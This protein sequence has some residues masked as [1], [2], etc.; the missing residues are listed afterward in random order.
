GD[1]EQEVAERGWHL[2]T[3]HIPASQPQCMAHPSLPASMHGTSQPPSLNAWHIPAPQETHISPKRLPTHAPLPPTHPHS[4]SPQP[5]LLPFPISSHSPCTFPLSPLLSLPQTHN[6]LGPGALLIQV[7]CL[8]DTSLSF[9]T[10]SKPYSPSSPNSPTYSPSPRPTNPSP[11]DPSRAPP[12]P[13]APPSSI[14]LHCCF[15]STL[16]LAC[17]SPPTLQL[18]THILRDPG[19]Q[20]LLSESKRRIHCCFLLH[21]FPALPTKPKTPTSPPPPPPPPPQH[22]FPCQPTHVLLAA[23][24][25]LLLG[26]VKRLVHTA[27]AD[28]LD[29]A[30]LLQTEK[31]PCSCVQDLGERGGG[32]G[33][34]GG[35]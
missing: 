14:P 8:D 5:L 29:E 19:S 1:G 22:P 25:Q 21:S 30:L 3:W 13:N 7:K 24:R 20:L 26:E 17:P 35:G 2:N 4:Q 9:C 11:P 28:E 23:G 15:R 34:S 18:S 12:P 31:H 33:D 32:E 10:P 27:G 16:A 6:L